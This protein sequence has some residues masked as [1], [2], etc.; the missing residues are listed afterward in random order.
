MSFLLKVWNKDSQLTSST[1]KALFI[2]ENRKH[3][4]TVLNISKILLN[5]KIIVDIQMY[6]NSPL[7]FKDTDDYSIDVN[8]N[9]ST[10]LMWTFFSF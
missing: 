10:F 4:K 7:G 1:V 8:G 3:N 5:A 2:P 9:L 6:Y